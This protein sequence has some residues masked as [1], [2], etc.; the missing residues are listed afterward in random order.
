MDLSQFTR[1]SLSLGDSSVVEGGSAEARAD[2][3]DKVVCSGAVFVTG[4]IISGLVTL[5]RQPEPAPRMPDGGRTHIWRLRLTLTTFRKWTP[6]RSGAAF[7][8][9]FTLFQ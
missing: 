1:W 3:D 7:D 8:E 9:G 6:H 4:L 2:T 5:A